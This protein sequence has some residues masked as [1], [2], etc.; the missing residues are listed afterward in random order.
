MGGRFPEISLIQDGL[1]PLW[2][3]EFLP[4]SPSRRLR[5]NHTSGTI[6]QSTLKGKELIHDRPKAVW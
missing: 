4:A 2:R 1:N 3:M 6:I 5:F